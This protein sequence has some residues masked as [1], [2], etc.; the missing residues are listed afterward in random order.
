MCKQRVLIQHHYVIRI[1]LLISLDKP[2]SPKIEIG[3]KY[4]NHH[5]FRVSK[6]LLNVLAIKPS[7]SSIF[8]KAT[9]R[10][11]SDKLASQEEYKFSSKL[12]LKSSDEL[13]KELHIL[14]QE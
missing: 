3:R 7:H 12:L 6:E 2:F 9:E 10:D 13:I 11:K 1:I 14:A 8:S 4:S 5:H